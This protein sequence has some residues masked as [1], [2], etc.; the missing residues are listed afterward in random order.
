[1]PDGSVRAG[2]G[3]WLGLLGSSGSLG[4]DGGV[5]FEKSEIPIVLACGISRFDMVPP[6]RWV[7][8]A[9]GERMHYFRGIRSALVANGFSAHHTK[10]DWAGPIE[11]R[12]KE[13]GGQVDSILASTGCKKVHVIAHS[14]GG[15]DARWMIAKLDYAAKVSNLTTIGTPHHG[16]G[17]ADWCVTNRPRIRRMLTWLKGVGLDV[18]GL[19]DLTTKSMAARNAALAPLEEDNGVIYRTWG[20]QSTFW[21]TFVTLKP[22]YLLLKHHYNEPQN[23]GL[24]PLGSARWRP[25]F[26][27][28]VLPW[29]HLTQL[30]WWMP[31][32]LAV[33][34]VIPARLVRKVREFYARI[35]EAGWHDQVHPRVR[36]GAAVGWASERTEEVVEEHHRATR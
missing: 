13:L 16:T 36:A 12:A 19:C 30:A 26:F 24:V 15:L 17:A 5:G 23:D 27:Q 9:V 8:A 11:K 29:D 22:T 18:T 4:Y 21:S 10:V 7:V 34:D 14:M 28:G 20:G 25:E 2:F 31:S 1:M 3:H 35:A 32:R 6:W 33:G